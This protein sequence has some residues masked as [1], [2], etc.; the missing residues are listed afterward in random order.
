MKTPKEQ[1]LKVI[2]KLLKSACTT[3]LP[4]L[5]DMTATPEGFET[6][7]QMIFSYCTENGVSVQTAM[8]HIDSEL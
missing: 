2:E 5:C 6:A 7:Q 3:N 4:R 8:A 1:L